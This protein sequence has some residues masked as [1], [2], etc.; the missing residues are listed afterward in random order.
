MRHVAL[1][2]NAALPYDCKV[3]T[4]V[5]AYLREG[6]RW[7]IYIEESALQEQRLPDLGRWRGDGII[8][9][10]DDPRVARAVL[11]SGLR[12]VGFGGG[13]G[14]YDPGSGIPYCY[15]DNAA[16]ARLAADHL[17]ERGF[18]HFAFCGY[19]S[20]PINGWS[21]DRER[22]FVDYVRRRGFDCV[23]YRGHHRGG[24]SWVE[25]QSSLGEWLDRLPKPAGLMAANDKRARQ[26][27]EVCRVRRI[28]VPEEVAVIGVDN[29]EMLCSLSTPPLSSVEQGAKRI[30]YTAASL[31]DRLMSG[32]RPRSARVIVQPEA[33]ITRQSTDVLAITDSKVAEAVRL[34]R[35]RACDRLS[36]QQVADAVALSRSGLDVRFKAAMGRSVHSEIRA[37]Q[38]RQAQVLVS[39]T[40]LPLKEISARTGFKTIQHM[41]ALF[42]RTFRVTPARY[43][44]GA[45]PG[46]SKR[47]LQNSIKL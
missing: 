31:L 27:L 45:R 10:F 42:A 22:S 43:R 16:V 6:A 4:G 1:I 34:I 35:E 41:T 3:M 5:A 33:C 17:L 28:R 20:T 19:P 14:W 46:D 7:N 18:R 40:N 15:T 44:Q 36:V 11:R 8:A 30:G 38:L 25:L 9:D 12:A 26:V 21:A 39:E 24:R 37:V 29:D 13:Y 47:G 32:R 23:T 2:Y